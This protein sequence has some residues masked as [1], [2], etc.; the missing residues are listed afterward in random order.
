MGGTE[1]EVVAELALLIAFLLGFTFG[2]LGC[3]VHGS[4]RGALL[5]SA[6][7]D[8][9]SAGVRVILGLYTRD[10]DGYLQSLLRRE[11]WP[12]AA[13]GVNDSSESHERKVDQ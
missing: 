4:R 10:D 13:A 8:I 5:A 6:S 2:V 9:V 11:D 1:I 3:V 12:P 7:D